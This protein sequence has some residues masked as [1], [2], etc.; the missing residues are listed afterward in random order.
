M[1]FKGTPIYNPYSPRDHTQGGYVYSTKD[2]TQKQLHNDC[3]LAVL[4]PNEIVIPVS[5]KGK[6]VAKLAKKWLL[7]NKIYLPHLKK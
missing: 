6:P 3:V 1:R 4:R 7:S 2:M 5:Y